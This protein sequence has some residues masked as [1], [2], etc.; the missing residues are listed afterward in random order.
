MA[1]VKTRMTTNQRRGGDLRGNAVDMHSATVIFTAAW[2]DGVTEVPLRPVPGP[3]LTGIRERLASRPLRPVFPV[4]AGL[5]GDLVV[6]ADT[7]DD[8]EKRRFL[9]RPPEGPTRLLQVGVDSTERLTGWRVMDF[10]PDSGGG[11][12][13][14]EFLD[15]GENGWFNRLRH[16][17][18]AG[19][20]TW[21]RQGSVDFRNTETGQL[22][23]VYTTL[24]QTGD[25]RLWVVPR[26]TTAGLAA[27]D[28]V[29]GT[30]LSITPLPEDIANL[31]VSPSGSAF[32]ALMVERHGRRTV[33]LARTDLTNGRTT[34]GGTA[35]VP[36]LDLC[37]ADGQRRVHARTPDGIAGLDEAGHLLWRLRPRGAV[38]VPGTRRLIVAY[39]GET[40]EDVVVIEHDPDGT[41]GRR[42]ALR[43]AGVEDVTLVDV[44]DGPRFVLHVDGSEQRPGR[45]I[46]VDPTGRTHA[47]D[48]DP[49]DVSAELVRRES[50]MDTALMAVTPD[51]AVLVPFSDPRGF[52]VVRFGR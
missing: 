3:P 38:I 11:L 19:V 36:L 47:Y 22:I 31:V 39:A 44:E 48:D 30:T 32:Y 35:T 16:V 26:A 43:L 37:G 42:W 46:V 6:L 17:T 20:T 25:G 24:Q 18:S 1:P 9:H 7:E 15:A 29:D 34:L 33:V 28:P 21:S 51:G 52:G 14:L 2:G 27:I 4:R 41:S 8:L 5:Y 45:L 40:P 12:H 10:R 13:L 49:D 50:R 23:G